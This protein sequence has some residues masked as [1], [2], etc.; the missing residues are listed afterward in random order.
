[1]E[2]GTEEEEVRRARA[3]DR[4][5]F[6]ALVER[7]WEGVRRWLY[8]LTRH[9]QTAEDLAQD[10]FVRAWTRLPLLEGDGH[11][12][13]WLFRIARNLAIDYRRAHRGTPSPLGDDEAGRDPDPHGAAA[14]QELREAL[15]RACGQLPLPLRAAYLLRTQQDMPYAEI[16]QTL[17]ISE[18][19]ARW[20]VCKARRLLLRELRPF[21]DEPK[22]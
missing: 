20:R 1:V 8:A 9:P 22:P 13:A 18:E 17:A 7:H 15:W 12:R 11:F 16:A 14:E 5:A 21:L 4:S 10:T 19:L 6:D 3:G 2:Q